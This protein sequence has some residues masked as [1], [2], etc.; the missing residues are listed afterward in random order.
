MGTETERWKK[1]YLDLLDQHDLLKKRADDQAAGLRRGLVRLSLVAEGRDDDL[2]ARLGEIRELL[3]SEQI[4]GLNTLLDRVD[5][6]LERW[7]QQRERIAEQTQQALIN[8]DVEHENLPKNIKSSLKNLRKQLRKQGSAQNAQ[9]IQAMTAVLREWAG[10][11]T[12]ESSSSSSF[13]GRLFGGRSDN[14]TEEKSASTSDNQYEIENAQNEDERVSAEIVQILIGMLNKLSLPDADMPKAQKLISQLRQGVQDF[15]LVPTLETVAQLIET[16]LGFEQQDFESFLKDVTERLAELQ[17]WLSRSNALEGEFRQATAEFDEKMRDHFAQLRNTLSQQDVEYP[18]LKNAVS[19]QLDVVFST[20]DVFRQ[21]QKSREKSFE[22]NIAQL[23]ERLQK[24]ESE[25]QAAQVQVQ[26]H[27]QKAMTDTLTQ[28]PNR[29]AYNVR[30]NQEFERFKRY[31]NALSVM[32]CDVDFFKRI[33]D[34]YGH[35]A[36]D[37]VLQIIAK[38][39]KKGVRETD[40]VARYGGEEFVVLLPE[41]KKEAAML[42][43]EKIRKLVEACPFH[44]RGERVQITISCGISEFKAGDDP[45]QVFERA[46]KALYRAKEEGRNRS[47]M[48]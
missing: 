6:S 1:K 13:F 12:G 23:T 30:L 14:T 22:D 35:Q 18:V 19:Q 15:E 45:V 43:A 3:R 28:L 24:M 5:Q 46:D 11:M 38:Q 34:G 33:N 37:K 39:V 25:L 2:D 7:Q 21:Q 27:R 10:L 31:G 40:L 20:L 48:G 41:S 8:I 4:T 44:F 29:E 42:A 36:G 47:I 16:A 32:V 17:E 26:Q 9:H